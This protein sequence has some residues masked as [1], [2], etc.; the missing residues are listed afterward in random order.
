MMKRQA[1]VLGVMAL[2][3]PLWLQ[4]DE[5]LDLARQSG[6]LAC[7]SIENK[8]V[9]P[10]WRNVA[11]RYRGDSEARAMLIDKVKRGGKSTNWTK[12]TGGI[13]MPPYSPRVSDVN[14]EA[15]VDFILALE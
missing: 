9:G 3:L 1:W 14:I 15:L 11:A 2:T 12:E 4:A 10:A 5:G 13:P 7:H 8:I 6:C